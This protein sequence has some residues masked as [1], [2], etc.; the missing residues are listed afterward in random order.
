MDLQNFFRE[1]PSRVLSGFVGREAQLKLFRRV[2]NQVLYEQTWIIINIS[3]QV[4]IGKTE[5]LRQY[6]KHVHRVGALLA[7]T[8]EIETDIPS[9]MGKLDEQLTNKATR[10]EN[11]AIAIGHK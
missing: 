5:L 3:G 11:L 9:V 2:L 1:Y 10:C 6:G 7:T 4:G 8:D